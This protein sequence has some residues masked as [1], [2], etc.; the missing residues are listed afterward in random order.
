MTMT[1]T[2]S[3]FAYVS[4][5]VASAALYAQLFGAEPIDNSPQ[6]AMFAFPNGT[7]FGVW[8]REVVQ[9]QAEVM[10]GGMEFTFRVGS[11]AEVD[12][13]HAEWQALGL[14]ILQPPVRMP[15]GYTFTATDPDGHRLRC[16]A[17]SAG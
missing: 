16:Y 15:F 1:S 8:G 5:A 13:R 10:G 3:T 4:D 14:A 2:P 17:S 6:H 9:P 11:D 7:T 12:Q